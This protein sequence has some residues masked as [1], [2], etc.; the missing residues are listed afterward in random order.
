MGAGMGIRLPAVFVV[1]SCLCSC[2]LVSP[3]WHWE[4]QGA[5]ADALEHDRNVCKARVYAGSA[6]EVT[7]G[8]VRRLYACMEGFGWSRVADERQ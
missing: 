8:S 7:Q 2:A 5:G 1:F 4:R 6:G 3:G